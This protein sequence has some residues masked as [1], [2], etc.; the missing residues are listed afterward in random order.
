MLKRYILMSVCICNFVFG[1]WFSKQWNID[2]PPSLEESLKSLL[3]VNCQKVDILKGITPNSYY[4]NKD[5]IS[6][7]IKEQKFLKAIIN[8]DVST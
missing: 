7:C 2:N 3:Q 5:A 6:Q 1:G 4:K 8:D